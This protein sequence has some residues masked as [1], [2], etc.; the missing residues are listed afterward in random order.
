[1]RV[2]LPLGGTDWGR[3]GIGTYVRS[4]IPHLHQALKDQ[5]AELLV[6]GNE[7]ELAAYSPCLKGVP[8]ATT[9]AWADPPAQSA[10]WYLSFAGGFAKQHGADVVLYPAA[11]RRCSVRQPVPSVAVVHDLGQLKVADKYDPLRMFYFKQVALRLI[12][13]STRKVAISQ[14]T[15]DDMV[16]ALK[17]TAE[18]IAV[19]P[20]GVDYTRFCPLPDDDAR[21]VAARQATNLSGP[22]LLYPARLEHPAKNHVRLIQAFARSQLTHTHHLALSGGDWGGK[23]LIEET[24]REFNLGDR[25]KL[26]GFVDE[27]HL[28][29]LIAGAEA[30]IMVGMTEGF[31]LPALEA[32]ASGRPVCAARAG[33]LP[34]VVGSLAAMCDPLDVGSIAAALERAALDQEFRRQ[35]ADDGPGWART[36]G[37]DVTGS[38]LAKVCLDAAGQSWSEAPT[39]T[40]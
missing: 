2:A 27:E 25:V 28:A 17:L 16:E 11:Q 13:N 30:V 19:V 9:P 18:S 39:R 15:R 3:S 4:I 31:G 5:D 8:V 37:W 24:I 32:L 7:K 21:V 35:C 26:L 22:Y 29:G 12:K 38:L 10:L 40:S 20:N 36:W 33:A 34:E 6:F 23:A 14:S 1:V